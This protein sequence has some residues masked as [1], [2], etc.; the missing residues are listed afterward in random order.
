MNILYI[1]SSGALSLIPFRKLLA[2]EQSISAVGVY[3]PLFFEQ[4]II[5]VE[6]ES[7]ALSAQQDAIPGR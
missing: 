1:G 4:K 5:A 3:N 6:N 7:L 2:T